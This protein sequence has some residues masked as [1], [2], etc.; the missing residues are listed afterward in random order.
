M[1]AVFAP[2]ISPYGIDDRSDRT[3][4]RPQRI[5]FWDDQGFSLRPFVYGMKMGRDPLSFERTY[6]EDT[7]KRFYLRFFVHSWEYR[8]LG[9]FRT[10]LHLLGVEEGGTINLF[11]TEALGRDLFSRVFHGAQISLSLFSRVVA[12]LTTS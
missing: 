11:G 2:F 9:L 7:S 8:L 12:I 6:E 3:F 10:D 1:A 4:Q 5:L